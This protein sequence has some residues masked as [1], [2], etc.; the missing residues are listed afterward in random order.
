MI[1]EELD[2]YNLIKS[3][4]QD[5]NNGYIY[6]HGVV[7]ND[8]DTIDSTAVVLGDEIAIGEMILNVIKENDLVKFSVFNSVLTYLSERKEE[9]VE[10]D[11]FFSEI[12]KQNN[13]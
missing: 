4:P 1:D 10:F 7:N 12:K 3:L 2:I 5:E 8:E 11:L 13:L 9:L 6:I